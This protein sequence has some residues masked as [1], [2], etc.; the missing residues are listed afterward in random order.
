M[1]L[2]ITVSDEKDVTVVAL[3]GRLDTKTAHDLEKSVNGL[4]GQG[5]RRFVLDLAGLEYLSSAGLRV[6]LMLAKRVSDEGYL[7]LCGLNAVVREVFDIAGFTS[8]FSI[9]PKRAAAVAAAPAVGKAGDAIVK[10]AAK[11]LGVKTS[12]P[13][14]PRPGAKAETGEEELAARAAR[15]LGV[16]AG[17]KEPPKRDAVG[18]WVLT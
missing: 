15:A 16:A 8:L 1:A 12:P 13:A 10:A 11:H 2:E 9:H 7:A 3:V 4:L 14:P 5:K 6:L 18:T 17:G